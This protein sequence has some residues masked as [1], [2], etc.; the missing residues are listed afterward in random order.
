[1]RSNVMSRCQFSKVYPK[2][3]GFIIKSDVEDCQTIKYIGYP[4]EEAIRG[5]VS[6]H[7][8]FDDPLFEEKESKTIK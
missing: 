4:W 8:D 3:F 1:M 5:L 2:E 6:Y 7:V